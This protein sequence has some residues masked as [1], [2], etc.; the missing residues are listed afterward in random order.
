MPHTWYTRYR[1]YLLALGW[2]ANIILFAFLA[3]KASTK[4]LLNQMVD[5]RD[6]AVV[7]RRSHAE[8]QHMVPL[9]R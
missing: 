1:L 9:L 5:A 2:S 8:A 7:L 3:E 6:S 4:P